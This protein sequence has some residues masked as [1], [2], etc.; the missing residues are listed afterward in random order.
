[1]NWQPVSTGAQ[2]TMGKRDVMRHRVL[3]TQS[4]SSDRQVYFSEGLESLGRSR[5]Q[6]LQTTTAA[7]MSSAQNG[8]TR[9][10][11][12]EAGGPG[13]NN[14]LCAVRSVT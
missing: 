2:Q 14:T 3:A 10:R 8:Q 12:A 7:L 13:S 4:M 5:L 1:M 11:V 9:S 6:C